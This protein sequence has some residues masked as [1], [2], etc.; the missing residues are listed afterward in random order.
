M[1]SYESEAR[2]TGWYRNHNIYVYFHGGKPKPK[3]LKSKKTK[4]GI[5]WLYGNP[6]GF[7][8]NSWVVVKN[9]ED[10]YYLNEK[11]Q[12]VNN[13]SKLQTTES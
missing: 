12:S 3:K 7:S 6:I 10:D 4:N 11:L 13:S 5:D 8:W 1:L 9:Y 2:D